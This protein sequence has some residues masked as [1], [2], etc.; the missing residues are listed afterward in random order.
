MGSRLPPIGRAWLNAADERDPPPARPE[1]A[2]PPAPDLSGA[3]PAARF[4]AFGD[5]GDGSEATAAVADLV[6][7][8]GPDFI[9][10]TGDNAYGPRSIADAGSGYFSGYIGFRSDSGESVVNRFFPTIGNHDVTDGGGLEDYLTAFDLP[11]P[12][13]ESPNPSG[14]ERYYDAVQG[15]VHLFLLSTYPGE[16]DGRTRDSRQ[17]EWLEAAMDASTSRWQVVVLHNA[18]YSSA[19]E[20]GSNPEVQWPFEQWGA[21]L[22]LAGHD[23]VYERV[24]RDDDGDGVELAYLVTG[25]GGD[26]SYGFDESV[27]G[28]A[29]RYR[30]GPGAVF[31]DAD[32]STLSIEFVTIDGERVDRFVVE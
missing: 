13:V 18:P 14:N 6:H 3:G 31:V 7:E 25:L 8:V 21:D 20:H 32:R 30:N 4:A 12:G 17:A 10:T 22:V 5:Y 26:T 2:A 15:P 19:D 16:P 9:V 29:V 28:S 11:G 23:H 27:Q 1:R 24:M